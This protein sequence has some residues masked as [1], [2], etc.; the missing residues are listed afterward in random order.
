[1]KYWHFALRMLTIRTRSARVVLV[2]LA[3]FLIFGGSLQAQKA[4]DGVDSV[5]LLRLSMSML[6]KSHAT[7]RADQ[8]YFVT[9]AGRHCV[10]SLGSKRLSLQNR[11]SCY[12]WRR[13]IL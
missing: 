7:T 3:A 8:V 10:R 13:R 1:M 11:L 9:D 4:A 2:W 12:D 6:R 5:P